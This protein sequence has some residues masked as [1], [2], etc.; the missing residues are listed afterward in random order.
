VLHDP[1][2][3]KHGHEAGNEDDVRK[4]PKREQRAGAR[5]QLGCC[6]EGALLE[7]PHRHVI[8]DQVPEY[9]APTLLGVTE[10]GAHQPVHRP[11]EGDSDRGPEHEQR[12]QELKAEPPRD[13]TPRDASAVGRQRVGHAHEEHEAG[14]RPEPL[15]GGLQE[16]RHG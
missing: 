8:G 5:D 10:H 11:K 1:E 3:I 14:Q 4:D 9:E 2:V 6:A 15:G 16:V 7:R 13:H 12:E